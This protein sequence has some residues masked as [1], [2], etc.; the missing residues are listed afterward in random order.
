MSICYS[1]RFPQ[2]E[3]HVPQRLAFSL[4]VKHICIKRHAAIVVFSA[5]FFQKNICHESINFF[6]PC[7]TNF[8]FFQFVWHKLYWLN[9]LFFLC[10]QSWILT[11]FRLCGTR[12]LALFF[13]L[14]FFITFPEFINNSYKPANS[15]YQRGLNFFKKNDN[16]F[17]ALEHRLHH[18]TISG[19]SAS[20]K[21]FCNSIMEVINCHRLVIKR[22]K[23]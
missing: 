21:P 20:R 4:H 10:F 7:I 8:H 18:L 15:S 6:S 9:A 13:I 19:L 1:F 2:H 23:E 14:W 22:S 5:Y 11:A 17:L 12:L 3:K 16:H